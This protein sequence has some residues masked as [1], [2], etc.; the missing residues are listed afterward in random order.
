M[1][2]PVL[3]KVAQI[4][5]LSTEEISSET[6]IR[7]AEWDSV[8]LLDLIATIDEAYGVTVDTSALHRCQTVGEMSRLIDEAAASA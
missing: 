7:P 2:Q 3:E 5:N 8:D 1:K 4:G 6:R